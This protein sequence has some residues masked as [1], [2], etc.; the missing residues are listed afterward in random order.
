[1]A[2]P[3][4]EPDDTVSASRMPKLKILKRYEDVSF[5]HELNPNKVVWT[6]E[7]L[8]DRKVIN[9]DAWNQVGTF[10]ERIQIIREAL[11]SLTIEVSFRSV[12][13]LMVCAWGLVSCENPN[14]SVFGG[15]W[16][17]S[18][19]RELEEYTRLSDGILCKSSRWRSPP[20][21][22]DLILFTTTSNGVNWV[23]TA[24]FYCAA[25]LRLATKEHD[26]LVKAWSYLPEHYQSFYKT[27]L[28]FSLSLDHECLKCLWRLL[29]KSTTI[30]NS[31]APFLLAF[32]ELS[33]SSKNRAICKTLFESHLGF[34]GLHAY[35]V[36]LKR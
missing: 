36:Y 4:N 11:T 12:G 35:S 15:L 33:G 2:T 23:R 19:A 14:E 22:K 28:E 24:C 1:M 9:L 25:V 8:K 6:N 17:S 7:M 26:A 5:R 10:D 34:T 31:V 27:P 32:Q 3:P 21:D 16:E 13:A 18:K 29:Q 30:R 20:D